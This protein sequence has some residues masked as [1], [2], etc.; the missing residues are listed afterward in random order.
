MSPELRDAL[1]AVVA[2][3]EAQPSMWPH[4]HLG[5]LL[6]DVLPKPSHVFAKEARKELGVSGNGSLKDWTESMPVEVA[7]PALKRLLAEPRP[8]LRFMANSHSEQGQ[9]PEQ[10]DRFVS[11]RFPGGLLVAVMDGVGSHRY[12]DVAAETVRR[13]FERRISL[14]DGAPVEKPRIFLGNSLEDARYA[15]KGMEGA[16][17]C[18]ALLI[19]D[20]GSTFVAHIGDCAAY[21][22][23]SK[24]L[25]K[26]TKPD[27]VGRHLLSRAISGKEGDPYSARCEWTLKELAPALPGDVFLVASDGCYE[28]VTQ[29]VMTKEMMTARQRAAGPVAFRL[30]K[31]S[32]DNGSTDNSTA[33][34]VCVE[35]P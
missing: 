17:T 32:L 29:A 14:G 13:S 21:R 23:R 15:L 7:L 18:T 24:N 10:S 5:V 20:D 11:C 19:H 22:L 3:L 6:Q 33:I 25:R 4:E 28:D 12:G 31:T 1:T 35:A 16:T 30:V 8:S 27:R 34:V 2:R 26:L 9:R